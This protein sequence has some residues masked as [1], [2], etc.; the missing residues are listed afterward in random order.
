ML[1]GTLAHTPRTIFSLAEMLG[2]LSSSSA[3]Y[4][5]PGEPINNV[6]NITSKFHVIQNEMKYRR[7]C[8]VNQV[9]NVTLQFTEILLGMII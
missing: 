6:D 8:H 4:F 9:I 5:S 7:N 3:V 2:I 1:I